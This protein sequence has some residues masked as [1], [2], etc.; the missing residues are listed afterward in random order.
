L[1]P[2]GWR[3]DDRVTGNL[4]KYLPTSKVVHIEIDP[5]EI[6]KNVK[7]HAPVL[8]DAKDV[9]E[10]LLPMVDAKDHPEWVARFLECRRIEMEKVI[11]EAL[12]PTDTGEIRMGTGNSRSIR[13]NQREGHRR[14]GCRPA[15]DDGRPLL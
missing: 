1:W 13:S 7:A 4:S 8:G 9:L 10:A 14:Y 12:Q 5:A 15:P 6:N 11:T 2:S 3:F